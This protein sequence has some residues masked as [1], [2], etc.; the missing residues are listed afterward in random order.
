VMAAVTRRLNALEAA[1]KGQSSQNMTQPQGHHQHQRQASISRASNHTPSRASNK[2]HSR[3]KLAVRP[4]QTGSPRGYENNKS[5]DHAPDSPDDQNQTCDVRD[6][7]E[8][9]VMILEHIAFQRQRA[10]GGVIDSRAP[11][12]EPEPEITKAMQPHPP[13]FGRGSIASWDTAGWTTHT[14]R[15]SNTIFI[16]QLNP[17]DLFRLLHGRT[18][19]IWRLLIAL[20]PSEQQARF[21]I[22]AVRCS[23]VC[24]GRFT[25]VI[26]SSSARLIGYIDVS[27]Y[28]STQSCQ[29]CG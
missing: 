6:E 25:D 10:V 17:S 2:S 16:P 9:A 26:P 27:F 15:P 23:A 18:E 7:N 13:A 1:L 11:S 22:D 19:T 3:I 28:Y 5:S 4:A 29:R 20:L 12:E 21:C 14:G 8:D 24:Y